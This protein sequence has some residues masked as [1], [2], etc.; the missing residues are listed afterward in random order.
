MGA[1]NLVKEKFRMTN[2]S[3]CLGLA[4]AGFTLLVGLPAQSSAA[5]GLVPAPPAGIEPVQQVDYN[6]RRWRDRN[7]THVRAPFASVDD[8][9][10]DTYVDAPFARVYSGRDGTWVRAPFVNLW[11]PR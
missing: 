8:T 6:K 7:G 3:L 9:G 2:R 5:P 11:I 1:G 10:K 4:A